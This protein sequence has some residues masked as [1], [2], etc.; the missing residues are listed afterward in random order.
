MSFLPCTPYILF[1]PLWYCVVLLSYGLTRD[2]LFLMK[3]IKSFFGILEVSGG[4]LKHF[5]IFPP[6]LM[7]AHNKSPLSRLCPDF[8]YRLQ[9][10]PTCTLLHFNYLSTWIS[11]PLEQNPES[12]HL[13]IPSAKLR[14]INRHIRDICISE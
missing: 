6:Q 4:F 10:P 9:T 13:C 8:F 7:R 11:C 5:V 14:V 3:S 1:N 2:C 12:I